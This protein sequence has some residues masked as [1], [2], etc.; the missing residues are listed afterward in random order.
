MYNLLMCLKNTGWVANS[1]DLD[2]MPQSVS[3]DQGLHCLLGLFCPNT[4]GKY[5]ICWKSIFVTIQWI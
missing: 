1:V 4:Y 5:S 2:Q 3:F